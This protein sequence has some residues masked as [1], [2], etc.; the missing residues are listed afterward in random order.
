MLGFQKIHVRT[1]D[2]DVVVLAVAVLPQLGRAE[3]EIAFGTGKNFRYLSAHE[4]CASLS[5]Q[6]S[7]A[8]SMFHAFTGWDIV[9]QFAQVGKTLHGKYGQHM[10]NSL[11]PSMRFTVHNSKYLKRQKL[12]WSISLSFSM[13]GPQHVPLSMKFE[14]FYSHTKAIRCQLFLPPRLLYSNILEEQSCKVYISGL[15]LRCHIVKCHLLLTG[16]GLVQNSGSPRGYICQK[17]EC[18][19]QSCWSVHVGA[20]VETVNV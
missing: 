18:P 7:V 9:S 15:V 10:M 6:K 16:V 19:V 2:S 17:P 11:Q 12:H 4:I 20:D 5:P 8:L 1:V 13:T 14:S 3:L